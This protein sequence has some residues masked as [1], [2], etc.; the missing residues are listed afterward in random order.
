[1]LLGFRVQPRPSSPGPQVLPAPGAW[2]E[3]GPEPSSS[4]AAS[5]ARPPGL[6]HFEEQLPLPSPWC[7]QGPTAQC[8][9]PRWALEKLISTWICPVS[10]GHQVGSALA[11]PSLE[12]TS[13]IARHLRVL[14][15]EGWAGPVGGAA[16][17]GAQPTLGC[18][19]AGDKWEEA[20]GAP[21]V[22]LAQRA[23]H[24]VLAVGT[25]QPWFMWNRGL[26]WAVRGRVPTRPGLSP[27]G[28]EGCPWS[29]SG[30][31]SPVDR[32][33]AGSAPSPAPIRGAPA[34]RSSG[35]RNPPARRTGL[36]TSA[37][38]GAPGPR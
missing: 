36:A 15:R 17:G 4:V 28:P 34:G 25:G 33:S 27:G 37:G 1:M 24:L 21:G 13:P 11:F 18:P 6:V 29:L 32:W 38:P 19:N 20:A 35:G 30:L 2:A 26:G 16:D 9:G 14:L 23:L 31:Q 10:P 8:Q 3:P 7:P 12:T 5:R 22:P